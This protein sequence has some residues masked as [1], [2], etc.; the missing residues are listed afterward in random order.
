ML[1]VLTHEGH[2]FELKDWPGAVMNYTVIEASD[3]DDLQRQVDDLER[4]IHTVGGSVYSS[5]RWTDQRLAYIIA[6]YH[7]ANVEV[8][9]A[10]M[11][12][13]ER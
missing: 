12:V 7:L 5:T 13:I 3:P 8:N 2:V 4:Q 9:A 10:T 1:G 11:E 6:W